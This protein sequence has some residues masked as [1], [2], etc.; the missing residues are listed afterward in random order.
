MADTLNEQ[1]GVLTRR[2]IEAR[3]LRPLLGRL[4]AEIGRE[5]A[6]AILAEVVTDEAHAIGRAMRERTAS[7]LGD[8]GDGDVASFASGWEPWFRGGALEIETHRLDADAWRFDVTRCR[9][10]ELYHALGMADLGALL[11]CRRDA[12]LVEGYDSSITFERTQTIMEG[13]GHCDFHYRRAAAR[14]ATA[15]GEPDRQDEAPDAGT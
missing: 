9:Y 6:R 15:L 7:D 14:P 13:A 3:I 11:S 2:E 10:A 8:R 12:A 1:V 4:E 5:R